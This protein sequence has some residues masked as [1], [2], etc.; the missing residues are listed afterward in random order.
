MGLYP[1][2]IAI[3]NGAMAEG[4][5]PNRAYFMHVLLLLSFNA[6]FNIIATKWGENEFWA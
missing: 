1:S 6:I 4:Q 3:S 5:Q 2:V